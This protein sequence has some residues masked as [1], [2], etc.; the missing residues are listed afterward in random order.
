MAMTPVGG[1]INNESDSG[2]IRRV[3]AETAMVCSQSRQYHGF[4]LD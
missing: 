2:R 4:V 3:Q 1:T